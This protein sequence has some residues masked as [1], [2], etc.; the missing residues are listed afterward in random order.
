MDKL[1]IKL[2]C[3][4][5]LRSGIALVGKLHYSN[6][7]TSPDYSPISNDRMLMNVEI[8]SKCAVIYHYYETDRRD[9]L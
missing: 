7:W 4:G 1:G 5:A 3:S 8:N 9:E 2:N 6:Y